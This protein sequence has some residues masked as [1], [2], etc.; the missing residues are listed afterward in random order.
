MHVKFCA[1]VALAL[2]VLGSAAAGAETNEPPATP[3]SRFVENTKGFFRGPRRAKPAPPLAQ[4]APLAEGNAGAPKT[5]ADAG[6]V[7]ASWKSPS[8]PPSKVRNPPRTMTE[9]MAQE[10]P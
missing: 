10:R 2:I 7:K 1:S 8:P 5:A 3:W 4:N 9:Y 6:V